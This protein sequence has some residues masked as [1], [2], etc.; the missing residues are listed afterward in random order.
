MLKTPITHFVCLL[1]MLAAV[2][3]P[4]ALTAQEQVDAEPA[5]WE[6]VR[7]D[8]GNVRGLN[9][10]ASYA[11]SDVAMWRFYDHDQI[12]RELGYVKALGAN[13]IRVWLA[14]V[15]YDAEGKRFID[16]FEDF[17]S[18][19]E[20]H[21]ITVM[22]ILWDSCFGDAKASYEDVEDWVANPGTER[23][24]D[25]EFRADGDRYIRA[26]VEAGRD[27]RSLLIWDVMNEPSGPKINSWLEHY[28]KL[29]KSLDKEHPVTIGW[30]HAS[31]NNV[32]VDWVDVM[33]YH[34]YGIFDKNR[35][36]W[37]T[38]V[39]EIANA[40]G[41]KPIL[42]TEAGGPGFGQRYEECIDYFQKEGVGFYLFE[43][44]VGTNRFRNITGFVFPDGSARELKAITAFQAC[45][46][47]HGVVADTPFKQS[48]QKLPYS[49]SRAKEIADLVLKW[50][51]IELTPENVVEH[52]GLL[53]WTFISLA[54][55]GALGDHIAEAQNLNAQAE[56]AQKEGDHKVLKET[57]SKLA[58]LAAKLL[59]EHGF[60]TKAGTPVEFPKPEASC[61]D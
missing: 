15:V 2:A 49:R 21:R 31:S 53:R 19:C 8:F 17:L 43:A 37:T 30:A 60:I 1:A 13:S 10:I 16:K 23:V 7:A 28:C 59:V 50:D 55:G 38:A 36:V 4:S 20:K 46:G 14:W 11:P 48:T 25:L 45:A 44:M 52:Q 35:H 32:S 5:A 61:A 18:L 29:V 12:D 33:S 9:Y 54:W 51:S 6:T 41:N 40:H 34:P 42:V 39:R 27:N 56:A 47:R 24:A 57:L 26:V 22:P 58:T 3:V